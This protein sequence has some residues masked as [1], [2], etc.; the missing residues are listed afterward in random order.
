[1]TT[2]SSLDLAPD[3]A[4]DSWWD[5]LLLLYSLP[6]EAAVTIRP[7]PLTL[8][9]LGRQIVAG[10]AIRP[11]CVVVCFDVCTVAPE[12]Q[13]PGRD[14]QEV[15]MLSTE[16]AQEW[17]QEL[18]LGTSDGQDGQTSVSV[19]VGCGAVQ[20]AG[21]RARMSM[22]CWHGGPANHGDMPGNQSIG[23]SG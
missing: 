7:C 8:R 4:A 5:R 15:C 19:L 16:A 9:R 17:R 10:M 14:I 13:R 21:L 22:G 12:G 18:G 1:M 20:R 6:P 3:L 11:G 2:S 23:C